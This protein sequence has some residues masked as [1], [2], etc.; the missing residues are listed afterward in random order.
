MSDEDRVRS[1]LTLAAELPDDVQPPV[2][3]LLDR[4]H[5]RRRV[6]AIASVTGA[7]VVAAAA[8]TI[9][10][11]LRS[12]S[13]RQPIVVIPSTRT[14]T[15][16]TAAQLARFRWS[17]L[18][19]SPLGARSQPLLTWT[20]RYLIELAGPDKEHSGTDGAIYNPATGQW[21]LIKPVPN[22]IGLPNVA[23]AWTGQKLFVT[24]GRA[25]SW[26]PAIADRAEAALYDPV[27]NNWTFTP[28]PRQLDGLTPQ[29]ADWTGRDVILASLGSHGHLRIGAYDPVSGRWRMITPRLPAAHPPIGAALVATP[30]RVLLWSLWSK[31]TKVSKNGYSVHSGIDVLSL[32]RSGWTTVTGSWPQHQTVDSPVYAGGLVFLPP[33]QIWCG[34]CS[35]PFFNYQA[36]LV[37]PATLAW[38]H[39]TDGPTIPQR[40]VQPPI[41]IWTGRAAIAA[42]TSGYPAHITQLAAYDPPARTWHLLPGPPRDPIAATPVWGGRQLF[43]L[44]STGA[45]LSL[46]G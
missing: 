25:F 34:A 19:R 36:R 43:L 3:H 21:H 12:E 29:A 31:S 28:L 23:T 26:T 18:A 24:D 30:G 44:T 10:V 15:G 9:P 42:N 37:N 7:A 14:A 2:G 41:W 27:T 38:R 13:A 45:L 32:G 4:G 8:F 6:R 46:H 39:I 17:T 5:R 11:A 35:H 40:I 22:T 20:G 16:P 1:L 33:S